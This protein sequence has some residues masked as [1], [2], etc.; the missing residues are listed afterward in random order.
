[1]RFSASIS[2]FGSRL[3]VCKIPQ[4]L[5]LWLCIGDE[6]YITRLTRNDTKAYARDLAFGEISCFCYPFF[7][8]F[9][10]FVGKSLFLFSGSQSAKYIQDPSPRTNSAHI[11]GLAAPYPARSPPGCIAPGLLLL[12]AV[13]LH[14]GISGW[15]AR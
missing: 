10:C 7:E 9:A 13:P 4:P 8:C 6:L 11:R 15:L 3:L 14:P 1:M 5:A 2:L 12:P